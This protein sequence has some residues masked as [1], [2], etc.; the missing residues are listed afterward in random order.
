LL[1]VDWNRSCIMNIF[2][3]TLDY[4]VSIWMMLAIARHGY[5]LQ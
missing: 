2:R 5:K 1:G 3:I 4:L